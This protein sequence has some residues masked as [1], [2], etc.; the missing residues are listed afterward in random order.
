MKLKLTTPN[1]QMRVVDFYGISV[2]IP[3]D[4]T[5]LSVDSNGSVYRTDARPSVGISCWHS[6]NSNDSVSMSIKV[7][8]S[9][10]S[11]KTLL[12]HYPED[13]PTTFESASRVVNYQGLSVTIPDQGY[14]MMD[15]DGEVYWSSH[16]PRKGDIAWIPAIDEQFCFIGKIKN[17]KVY[18]EHSLVE[19]DY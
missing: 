12:R 14:V 2:V 7:D 5:W 6:S 18:W 11:W 16:E 10:V 9:D 3:K 13:V 4:E 19:F 1:V 8:C 17:S 15:K